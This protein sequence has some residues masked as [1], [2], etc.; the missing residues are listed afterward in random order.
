MRNFC[1]DSGFLI[2]LYDS[3]D[4]Y[5]T[6]AQQLFQEN[7]DT[8][9]NRFALPW[10]IMYESLSTRLARDR[11]RVES[12]ERD[13]KRMEMR[14][15]IQYLDDRPFRDQ[16]FEDFLREIDKPRVHYRALSLVDRVVRL[17]LSDI[18]LKIDF[19]ITFN[20]GDFH[21]VCRRSRIVMIS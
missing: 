18:N 11:R 6:P 5:H 7:F 20:G 4:Q 12:V 16:A 19:L 2:A 13:L 1:V 8:P 15:Q 21:D 10:P 9:Y 14:K 17:M 3:T